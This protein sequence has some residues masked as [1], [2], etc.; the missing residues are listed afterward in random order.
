M[1]VSQP[2]R[3]V[4][5][6]RPIYS[7]FGL[8]W[9]V[10]HGAFALSHGPNPLLELPSFVPSA[11]LGVGLLAAMIVTTVVSMRAQRGATGR[12]AVVGNLLGAS[13]L[14]GFAALF[15]LITALGSTLSPGTAA[16]LWPTGSGLIVGLLYL[17]GGAAYRDV[18][19]YTLGAWLAVSSTAALFL[20]GAYLYWALALAGGGSYLLAAVIEP[21]RIAAAAA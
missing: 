21:R 3:T 9:L 13:W 16:T 15:F 18:L 1:Y 17:A 11:L 14:I 4:L 2:V 20:D 6:N 19:Q 7:S 12:E 8:A 5:D 10:G